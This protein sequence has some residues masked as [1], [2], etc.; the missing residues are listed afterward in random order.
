LIAGRTPCIFF[1]FVQNVRSPEVA[2]PNIK[3]SKKRM[4][5]DRKWGAR[6]RTERSRLRT[7]MKRVHQAEDAETAE[8]RLREAVSLLDRAARRRLHHPNKVARLK[9]QLHRHVNGLKGD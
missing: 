3:S 8:A 2:M 6:N 7:V 9:A 5:L 4:E 1:C